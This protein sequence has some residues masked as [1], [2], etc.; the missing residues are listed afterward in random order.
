MYYKMTKE[1][2]EAGYEELSKSIDISEN[3]ELVKQG[4]FKY[5]PIPHK[6]N[7]IIEGFFQSEKF[8]KDYVNSDPYGDGWIV[9]I[10]VIDP[11][12][13]STL[14]DADAYQDLVE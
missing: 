8:F 7:I 12:E 2:I 5:T 10:N 13:L 11:N 1:I 14:L 6:D 9:K 4:C 3:L